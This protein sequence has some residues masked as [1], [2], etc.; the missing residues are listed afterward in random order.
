MKIETSNQ[1]ELIPVADIFCDDEFNCRGAIIPTDVLSLA[2]SIEEKGLLQP[3]TV[4][5][6][7]AMEGKKYRIVAGHRRYMAHVVNEAK[8]I[9]AI[10]VKGLSELDAALLNLQENL[11]RASLNILQEA[12]AIKRFALAGWTQEEMGREVGR[13]KPWV[14]A[15]VSLLKL[16]EEIQ[17]E[18]A[19]GFLTQEHIR[20]LA[21]MKS[22][23]AMYEAVR[24]IKNAKLLGDKRPIK[25]AK[26]KEAF[27]KR[28]RNG[29]EI[30]EQQELLQDVIGNNLATRFAAWACGDISTY[31]WYRDI[32]DAA[33]DMGILWEIPADIMEE[34]NAV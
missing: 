1:V 16:P 8:E 12:L 25:I 7:T 26:K 23:D 14:Q 17:L 34:V 31:E 10:V 30:R 21:T 33:N 6:W 29:G 24:K 20:Q 5:P 15:R 32:R 4:Q 28:V 9:R 11:E 22:K 2:R 13:P 3:I 27:R 19:A 18:A